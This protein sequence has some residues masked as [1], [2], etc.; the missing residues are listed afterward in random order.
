MEEHVVLFR[1][2]ERYGHERGKAAVDPDAQVLLIQYGDRA[3]C[4]IA[5]NV[6]EKSGVDGFYPYKC[7]QPGGLA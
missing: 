3:G 2:L 4:A 1:R 5:K 7:S 6:P